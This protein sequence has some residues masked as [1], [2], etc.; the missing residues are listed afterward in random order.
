MKAYLDTTVLVAASMS[1]H[2][3]HPQCFQ[4][5]AA[6]KDGLMEACFSAHGLLEFYSVLTRAPFT[7]RVHPAQATLFLDENVLPF[8]EVVEVSTRDYK[9]ILATCSNAGLAGGMVYD[10][11]HLHCARKAEC[12]RLYTLNVKHFRSMDSGYAAKIA[13][14]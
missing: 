12:D 7:P 11:L 8:F 2:P 13:A 4:L 9:T 1:A 10:A 3:Q 5:L 14:P 6:V